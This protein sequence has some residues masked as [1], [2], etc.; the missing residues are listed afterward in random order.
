MIDEVKFIIATSWD[1]NLEQLL[2]SL[3]V[4][5][6]GLGEQLFASVYDAFFETSI[7]LK[8]EYDRFYSV[9]YDS[10]SDYIQIRYGKTLSNDDLEAERVFAVT[11]L[12]Q[13]VDNA[14]EESKLDVVM[15]T[16]SMLS[17]VH[18]ENKA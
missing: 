13:I 11:W 12:P 14:Y 15:N 16:I 1:P 7:N 3:G 6:G 5:S 10:L 17:K 18:N 9:E 4:S 8:E 2:S